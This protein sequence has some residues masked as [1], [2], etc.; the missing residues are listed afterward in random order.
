M[1]SIHDYFR[2][3]KHRFVGA[4]IIAGAIYLALVV[5]QR[6]GLGGI[7]LPPLFL[8]IGLVLGEAGRSIMAIGE[9][10][11]NRFQEYL[12]VCMQGLAW[13]VWTFNW[14][15]ISSLSTTSALMLNLIGPMVLLTLLPVAAHH[16]TK[17]TMQMLDLCPDDEASQTHRPLKELIA[18]HKYQI[19]LAFVAA[20]TIFAVLTIG[21]LFGLGGITIEP[22][23]LL[24]GLI[25]SAIA[26]SMDDAGERLGRQSLE[27]GGVFLQGLAWWIWSLNLP[28]V[29]E[30]HTFQ[31]ALL[32]MVAPAL[33]LGAL[34]V[35]AHFAARTLRSWRR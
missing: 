33:L 16:F 2:A 14:T 29:K 34:P 31:G 21:S 25:V 28:F 27:Y 3:H 11:R 15:F 4:L 5:G 10:H 9:A 6:M 7:S 12:G 26:T 13:W 30:L 1:R 17:H 24:L 8:L 23:L 19:L 20:I 18:A 22:G 32:H 35:V